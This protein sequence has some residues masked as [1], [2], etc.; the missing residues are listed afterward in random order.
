MW[1]TTDHDYIATPCESS[2]V[3]HDFQSQTVSNLQDRFEKLQGKLLR[4][5]N[6]KNKDTK[7]QFWT[8]LPNYAVFTALSA[9]L[10]TR[11]PNGTGILCYWRGE[12][13]QVSS[14]GSVKESIRKLTFEDELFLVLIKLKD[15]RRAGRL[16]AS[17]LRKLSFCL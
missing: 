3:S 6:I 5:E 12:S 15:A 2:D 11:T 14:G 10:K 8:N 13:T 9:Y 16:C 7:F 17:V 1:C 4:I